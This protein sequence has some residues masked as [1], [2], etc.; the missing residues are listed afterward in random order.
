MPEG[1]QIFPNLSVRENLIATAANYNDSPTPWN[2]DGVLTLFPQLKNRLHNM[3]DQLSGGEQQMLA[4]ARALML[5]PQLLILD[6]ATEGLAPL[7]QKDLWNKLTEIK[8][9]GIALLLIDKNLEQLNQLA[10]YHYL[11]E[12]GTIA[13]HGTPKMLSETPELQARYLGI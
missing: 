13:W 7:V 4:T 11:I 2:L 3:G 5:N 8:K 1:R 6:E 12:K 9:T 10:D